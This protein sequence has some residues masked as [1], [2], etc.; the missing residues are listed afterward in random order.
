MTSTSIAHYWDSCSFDVFCL[1]ALALLAMALCAEINRALA[2]VSSAIGQWQ[3]SQ[4][5]CPIDDLFLVLGQA[6]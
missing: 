5:L 4:M 6:Y 2:A 1:P 3:H